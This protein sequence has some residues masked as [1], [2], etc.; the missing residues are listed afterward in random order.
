MR[1]I[2]LKTFLFCII[3]LA[4]ATACGGAAPEE[5]P[6]EE[7]AP[8]EEEEPAEEE[9]AEEEPAEEVEVTRVVEAAASEN[10]WLMGWLSNTDELQRV[11]LD[12]CGVS[13]QPA[14]SYSDYRDTFLAMNAAGE[15]PDILFVDTVNLPY[16]AEQGLLT[17][18]DDIYQIDWD[19]F[20]DSTVEAFAY[21]QIY[22]AVPRE[23]STL[24]LY[25]NLPIFWET[26]LEE[27]G[28]DWNWDQLVETSWHIID[29]YGT[30]GMAVSTWPYH[31]APFVFQN[32][33]R[34]MSEDFWEPEIDSWQAIDAGYFYI[35]ARE[36]GWA[37]LPE[38][39]DRGWT[40]EAFGSGDVAMVLDGYGLRNYL[41]E[42]YPELEYGA[43]QLPAGPS[44]RGNILFGTGYAVSAGSSNPEAALQ[45]I[46]CLTSEWAQ[47]EMMDSGMYL[48]TRKLFQ[49]DESHQEDPLVRAIYE[50]AGFATPYSWGPRHDEIDGVLRSALERAFWGELT[51]EESF[52]EAAEEIRY[53]VGQ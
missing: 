52:M 40:G 35:Y 36:D 31:F 22:Y 2:T 17:P 38:D 37:V 43:V 32:D 11:L 30:P 49:E 25:Y 6:A 41:R 53:V 16:F 33:G 42:V 18:P 4:G 27:P 1:H 48:P 39:V 46:E 3:V 7:A 44:D 28:D 8:A 19:V 21:E 47:Y 15:T 34:I 29:A 50:G 51:V 24:A 12:E 20:M 26:G 5:A 10:V 13:A 9:P 45:A 14:V 23:F